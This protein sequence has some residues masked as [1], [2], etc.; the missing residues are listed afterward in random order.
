MQSQE[1]S[2]RGDFSQS[3]V[4]MANREGGLNIALKNALFGGL[5]LAII[6]GVGVIF[7]AIQT[8]NRVQEMNDMQAKQMEMYR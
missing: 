4:G 5:I 7:T 8:R 3:E 6:E 1:A 2:S